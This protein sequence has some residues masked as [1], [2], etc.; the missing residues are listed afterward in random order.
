M[1]THEEYANHLR[2]CWLM[3]IAADKTPTDLMLT[4]IAAADTIG[5]MLDPTLWIQKQEQMQQDKEIIEAVNHLRSVFQKMRDKLDV[6]RIP[7]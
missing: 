5:P 1:I 3:A 7:A 2:M 4:K 6:S